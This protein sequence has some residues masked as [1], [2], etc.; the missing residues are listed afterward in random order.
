MILRPPR[1]PSTQERMHLPIS[2][3]LMARRLLLTPSEEIPQNLPPEYP[4]DIRVLVEALRNLAGGASYIKV[5]ESGTAMRLLTAYI[6]ATGRMGQ[7]ITLCGEGRQ[8]E[9]PIAPLVTALRSLGA[10]IEY[11][12]REGYPPLGITPTSLSA[13]RISL[14]ASTSSQYLSALMLIAP[15][16]DGDDYTIDTN[17][18][19]IA[20]LPYAEMTLQC[21]QNWGYRWEEIEGVYSYKGRD[22]DITE[23]NLYEAD[24]TAASY[25]YL[26]VALGHREALH[27][28]DLSLP[29]LQGDSLHLPRIFYQLGVD[30][31][32]N[33]YGVSIRRRDSPHTERITYDCIECP[34]I[35][36]TVAAA[37]VGLGISFTL[38][39]VAH[40][41]IKESD[42]LEALRSELCKLNIS[43]ELGASSIS[44]TAAPPMLPAPASVQLSTHGDHRM[45]MALAPLF[46]DQLGCI[47]IDT[48]EVVTKSYPNYWEVLATLGYDLS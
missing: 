26:I 24:W 37:A 32:S 46:A 31:E 23:P 34:D 44:W 15:H 36:P 6:S 43:V 2:K 22:K 35:V 4:I 33:E 47:H 16:L 41:R 19:P 45:A 29:S 28:P 21:M 25:A 30:T 13:K 14:D 8:H 17:P 20:S 48:P 39:G 18:Y 40:L 3:S 10:D 9:R 27:L 12:E 5:G 38:N 7:R 42:R 1:I 11:L